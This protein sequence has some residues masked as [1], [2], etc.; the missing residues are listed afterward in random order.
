MLHRRPSVP[1]VVSGDWLQARLD[2]VVLAD[3]R[4]FL[5]GTPGRAGHADGHLPGAVWV[6]LD[7]DLSAPPTAEAGRH[8]LPTPERFAAAMAARGIPQ[9]RTVVAY[10]QGHG[11]FA[12]RLVWMLRVTGHDAAL[13]DGGLAAWDG[14]LEAG[15]VVRA[16]T[17]FASRPWPSEW[18]ADLDEVARLSASADPAVRI[19]DSR[20]PE[21][22]AG[23]VEPVDARAGHVPGAVN[24]PFAGNLGA[25]GR[26]LS[27]ADLA[28]RFTDAGL[29]Q[30]DDVI[31]YCGS[32]VT[33]C[34][35]LLALEASGIQAR[36]FPGSWSQWSGRSELPVAT[37]D[38][39]A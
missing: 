31:V 1:P 20:A 19:V 15:D 22:Y 29:D 28:R 27:E 36:L 32:G 24:L 12:S 5:D 23:E 39:G 11:G 21:R 4:W 16:P 35:N 17:E 26:L 7:H 9:D 13:L 2:E 30:A 14:P 18:L 6:D 25:D 3:V 8:P 38:D 10:D 34:Q 37:A 33:A